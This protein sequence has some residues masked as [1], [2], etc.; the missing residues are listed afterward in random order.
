MNHFCPSLS[1]NCRLTGPA[2][3]GIE[4]RHRQSAVVIY[5]QT[6]GL[7]LFAPQVRVVCRRL[8]SLS[9]PAS[10]LVPGFGRVFGSKSFRFDAP[11]AGARRTPAVPP[12]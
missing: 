3:S 12:R 7:D 2:S 5:A 4:H 6:V 8:T 11:A 10:G 9:P 1:M